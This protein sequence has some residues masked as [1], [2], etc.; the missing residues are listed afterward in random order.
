[1]ACALRLG[2]RILFSCTAEFILPIWL[3]TGECAHPHGAREDYSDIMLPCQRQ[4]GLGSRLLQQGVVQEGQND[5][6]MSGFDGASMKFVLTHAETEVP[7][8]SLP[9]S[10]LSIRPK[11]DRGRGDPQCQSDRGLGRNPDSPS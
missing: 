11:H 5:V 10:S 9:P 3:F 8:E 6:D 1:M 7:D 4:R 2:V